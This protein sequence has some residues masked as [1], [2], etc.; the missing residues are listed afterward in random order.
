MKFDRLLLIGF[1]LVML[2][3]VMCVYG[4]EPSF[5]SHDLYVPNEY[6]TE[7]ETVEVVY[8]DS[9]GHFNIPFVW[10]YFKFC[11]CTNLF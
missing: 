6:Y 2:A 9:D 11:I 10:L 8:A 1:V 7:L 5:T 3:T 4:G